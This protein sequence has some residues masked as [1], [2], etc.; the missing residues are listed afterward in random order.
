M[1]V[2]SLS[3]RCH[4]R[5]FIMVWSVSFLMPS[6]GFP[7]D[8]TASESEYCEFELSGEITS[9]DFERFVE[10]SCREVG[11]NLKAA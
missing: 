5:L 2:N 1:G 11:G 3:Y 7:A 8:I 9:G 6:P 10:R 4:W